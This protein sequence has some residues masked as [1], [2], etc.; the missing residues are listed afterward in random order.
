MYRFFKYKDEWRY[1]EKT[2]QTSKPVDTFALENILGVLGGPEVIVVREQPGSKQTYHITVKNG[3][4]TKVESVTTVT[5]E[6]APMCVHQ[7]TNR[8]EVLEFLATEITL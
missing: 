5:L 1:A 3:F 2:W 8:H 6:L 4:I 7:T